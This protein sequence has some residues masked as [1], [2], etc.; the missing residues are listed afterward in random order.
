MILLA[1][2]FSIHTQTVLDENF[3]GH[4]KKLKQKTHHHIFQ[5]HET[6]SIF[7]YHLIVKVFNM[8]YPTNGLV[9][10]DWNVPW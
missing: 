1:V 8:T 9:D 3:P 2:H 6:E 7:S 5:P 4:H 10:T